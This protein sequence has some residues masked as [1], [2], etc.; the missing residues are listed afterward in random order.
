MY[1]FPRRSFLLAVLACVA[2]PVTAAA[3]PH[4]RTGICAGVG[5]GMESVSWSDQDEDR[6][7]EGS[8]AANARVGYMVRPDLAV[9][10]EF[11]GWAKN[12]DISTE[13]LPVPV[14][15]KLTA[16][17][18]AVSYFPGGDAFFMRLGVGLAYGRVE[19]EPPPSVTSVPATTQSYTG[20]AVDFA[21]GFEFRMT[22]KFALGLQG[23]LVYLDLGEALEDVF[24]YGLSAQFNWYW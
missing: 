23:D 3:A 11:W 16:T 9:G 13:T 5:F 18:L 2:W 14:D 1:L 21:P 22:Q 4:V 6:N 10:V 20:F 15:V 24:G 12:Y 19:V 17:T 8:G 7:V